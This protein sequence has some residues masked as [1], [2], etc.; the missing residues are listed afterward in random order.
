MIDDQL[1]LIAKQIQQRDGIAACISECI[2]LVDL[3]HG[4]LASL[5]R[6]RV[7]GTQ[8]SFFLFQQLLASSKPF[9]LS[10]DLDG[11]L[12]LSQ[13]AKNK[14]DSTFPGM[15]ERSKKNCTG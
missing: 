4:Q 6:E 13:Q 10:D 9:L 7:S 5:G 8:M 2:L 1:S 14:A 12:A 15:V 11:K 3:D